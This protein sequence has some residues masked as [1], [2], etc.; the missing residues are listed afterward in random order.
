MV[1]QAISKYCLSHS[2]S[3]NSFEVRKGNLSHRDASLKHVATSG[4]EMLC[5][6]LQQKQMIY[7]ETRAITPRE[8]TIHTVIM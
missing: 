4:G 5:G 2:F 1:F 3:R 8:H 6:A 7:Q